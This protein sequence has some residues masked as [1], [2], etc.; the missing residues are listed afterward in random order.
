MDISRSRPCDAGVLR[1]SWATQLMLGAMPRDDNLSRQGRANSC[2]LKAIGDAPACY[3]VLSTQSAVPLTNKQVELPAWPIP[4]EFYAPCPSS[5]G[6]CS[7]VPAARMLV[8]STG[9]GSSA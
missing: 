4:G 2:H 3:I 7:S 5:R 6:D 9:C 8:I 1:Q